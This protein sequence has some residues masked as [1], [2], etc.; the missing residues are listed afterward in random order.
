VSV[1]SRAAPFQ[2][3]D[4]VV[5][6]DRGG[7]GDVFG[8]IVARVRIGE[9]LQQHLFAAGVQGINAGL[10]LVMFEPADAEVG[11]TQDNEKNQ[12]VPKPA[13]QNGFGPA[14]RWCVFGHVTPA[15]DSIITRPTDLGVFHVSGAAAGRP[16]LPTLRER[17]PENAPP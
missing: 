15:D 3:F 11:G 12:Q 8:A 1:T 5:V 6:E 16:P 2:P 7:G 14:I 13:L 4:A 17:R 9:I 10:Q